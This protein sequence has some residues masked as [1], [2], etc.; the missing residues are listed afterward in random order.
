[1]TRW[2]INYGAEDGDRF[3]RW[4]RNQQ[5]PSLFW[6]CRFPRL[7]ADQIRKNALIHDGLARATTSTESRAWLST[8]GSEQRQ[9]YEI[10]ADEVQSLV[11]SGLPQSYFM[12]CVLLRVPTDPTLRAKWL[13]GLT[14][15]P[16]SVDLNDNERWLEWDRDLQA[17]FMPRNLRVSFGD[18]K[19]AGRRLD[20]CLFGDRSYENGLAGRG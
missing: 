8:F 20:T 13:R 16:L 14:G 1:M 10:E 18:H 15:Q 2:L 9:E 17:Q 4:V 3:K 12:T 11:F 6:Y 7:S 5:R 19:R